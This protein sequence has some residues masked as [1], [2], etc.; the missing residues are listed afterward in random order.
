MAPA[1]PKVLRLGSWA[2]SGPK[3]HDLAA[4]ADV[5]DCQ[6]Q[7]R[8]QFFD[9]LKTKYADVSCITRTF[10]SVSQ[11]GRFDA[12]LA[13]HL[14]ESVRSISHC[15]AGYDQIDV[16]P[17]TA[18]NIQVSNVTS[19]VEAPTALTAVYL[20]L[21]AL[22]NFQQG[23]DLLTQGWWPQAKCAGAHVGR[24]PEG[25]TVGIVGM[26]GI[27]RAIRDRL[28]PFGFARFVYYNRTRLDADAEKGA[29]YMPL[30]A[31]VA[32]ADVVMLSVP[33]NAG[34][35]HLVDAAV[36]SRMKKGVV[37]INTARGAV[38]DEAALTDALLR[39][40]V[41][42]FGADVFEHEPQVSPR[43]YGL[44]NVVSLPHMGTHSQQAYRNMENFVVE[45]VRTYLATGT[46]LTNVPEQAGVDF[47]HDI[48]VP[49]G[50][51]SQ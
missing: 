28:A 13:L 35:R 46:M 36:L 15:G 44:P 47:Q 32:T 16:A 11:T 22:R 33:L 42:A 27:G 38:I 26:G 21:A 10:F 39:G 8:Q 19:P 3:W 2:L 29:Q 43:L 14:P 23:H 24:D 49:P 41:G 45:N 12:E 30:D 1:K 5:V 48:L 18:R 37:I 6:S 40:H 7:S 25:L 50:L 9:D 4:I 51:G 20:T 31:L 17:F 34:T